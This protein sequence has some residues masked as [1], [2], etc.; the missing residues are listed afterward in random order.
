MDRKSFLKTAG[1]SAAGLL[2][3]PSIVWSASNSASIEFKDGDIVLFIGDSITH[4][5][6]WHSFVK[7]FYSTRYPERKIS[8]INCGI[9]GDNTTNVLQRMEADILIHK[10][11][12]VVI[13]LGMN[14]SGTQIYLDK[15]SN[16]EIE[17]ERLRLCNIFSDDMNQIVDRLT[18]N[19][20]PQFIF[21]SPTIYD[22]TAKLDQI[23]AVGKNDTL[24]KITEVVERLAKEKNA[25]FIDFFHPMLQLNLEQQINNPS[26][27]IIGKDR[28]HSGS[29][30]HQL[31]AYYFLKAQKITP[32]VSSITI[33]WKAPNKSKT[34][35][36][37]VS[38]FLKKENL[39]EFECI[40]KNLPY[41]IGEDAAE[42]LKWIPLHQQINQQIIRCTHL[43]TGK[44]LLAIN[45]SVVG[46]YT[47]EVMHEGINIADK[48]TTPQYKQ[49]Q[50]LYVKSFEAAVKS[51][52]KRSIFQVKKML[53]KDNIDAKDEN[54]LKAYAA[55]MEKINIYYGRIINEYI[56][57]WNRLTE[58]DKEIDMLNQEVYALSKT[59]PYKYTI[60]QFNA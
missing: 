29:A 28:V 19:N 7:N 24:Q 2:L 41:P 48:N 4:N 8:F 26:Y 35:K 30:A 45:G 33:N 39:L 31:M 60:T 38:N 47:S 12:K 6:R 55:K 15:K 18:A 23:P 37:T 9:S 40:E 54:A 27:T 32:I 43:P 25:A 1:L 42:L 57:Y 14:N 58:L 34:I 3:V 46:T 16:E 17:K 53:L 36:A 20:H 52:M 21:V 56:Q 11:T 44:F 59:L 22:Q 13:M 10:P 49:A 51:S 50:Q 5:G